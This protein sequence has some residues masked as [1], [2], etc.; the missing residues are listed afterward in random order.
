MKKIIY[1]I[2]IILIK[3]SLY[4]DFKGEFYTVPDS[5]TKVIYMGPCYLGESIYTRFSM[6]NIGSDTLRVLAV[7]PSIEFYASQTAL[8]PFEFLRFNVNDPKLPININPKINDTLIV[9]YSA[10]LDTISS[11]LGRK[12]SM[13]KFGFMRANDTTKLVMLDSFKLIAKKTKKYLDSYNDIISIDTVLINRNYT[14]EKKWKIRNTWKTNITALSQKDSLISQPNGKEF[15]FEEKTYPMT[16]YPGKSDPEYII[17]YSPRDIGSDTLLVKVTFNPIANKMDSTDLCWSKLIA[18]GAMQSLS[19]YSNDYNVIGDTIDIGDIPIDRELNYKFKIYNSGSFNFGTIN[20]K[21]V[22][23]ND[24][25]ISQKFQFN[26]K[27]MQNGGH[28]KPRDSSEIILKAK[29]NE[30]GYFIDRLV[31]TSDLQSRTSIYG[32][33]AED[34]NKVF[35][36]KGRGVESRIRLNTDSI[37]FGNVVYSSDIGDDCP[38]TRDTILNIRN[39]GN[40]DLIINRI[41]FDRD[42]KFSLNFSDCMIRQG[43]DTNLIISFNSSFP[44][45]NHLAY[46]LIISDA[47]YPSDTLKVA[48]TATSV[49]PVQADLIINNDLRAKPGSTICIPILIKN[50]D[51]KPAAIAKTFETALS[52]NP[53][54]LRYQNKSLINTAGEGADTDINEIE[55]GKLKISIANEQYFKAKDTMLLLYFDIYL[56]DNVSSEIAFIDPKFGDGKCKRVLQLDQTNGVLTLDSVC[57]LEYKARPVVRNKF[58]IEDILPN[59]VNESFSIKMEIPFFEMLNIKLYDSYGN[60]RKE[61]INR[62]I[63]AGDYTFYFNVNEFEQGIYY[64]ETIAGLN[65]I[66]KPL[67]IAR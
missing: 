5:G 51:Y 66:V 58:K 42:T 38:S 14:L 13:F 18:S 63:P 57:G 55:P 65:K 31:I 22:N 32:Y 56:G 6:N 35:Y 11:A 30:K 67:I 64:I 48:L 54:I 28:L 29:I 12:E 21:I 52:Y 23:L 34:L 1:I 17:R 24:D 49:P 36:I 47:R 62:S 3:T 39:L 7:S 4:A 9:K 59:P 43:A 8:T 15:E 16:I 2:I 33:R 20:Q 45:E 61:W 19:L 60:L 26:K 25:N 44:A 27:F 41:E 37:D 53:S 10:E 50:E 46:L 40:K